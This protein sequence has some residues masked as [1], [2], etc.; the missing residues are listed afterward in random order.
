MLY[1]D[2]GG[3]LERK[4]RALGRLGAGLP[5]R[6]Y[7]RPPSGPERVVHLP[8]RIS[9]ISYDCLPEIVVVVYTRSGTLPPA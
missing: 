8:Y 7:D 4:A 1:G 5:A 9:S 3:N 6:S 2:A